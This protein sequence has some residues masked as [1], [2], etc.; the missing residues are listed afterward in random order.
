METVI[1]TLKVTINLNYFSHSEHLY[2]TIYK[3]L[4]KSYVYDID[5]TCRVSNG[6]NINAFYTTNGVK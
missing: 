1:S 4:T 3:S 2:Y 6:L 5:Y